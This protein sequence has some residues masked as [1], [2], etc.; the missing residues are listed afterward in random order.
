[1]KKNGYIVKL[2][3]FLIPIFLFSCGNS[4]NNNNSGNNER[5]VNTV[6]RSLMISGNFNNSYMLTAFSL[7]D[8]K[9]T[10]D[11]P[12]DQINETIQGECGGELSLVSTGQDVLTGEGDIS[13]TFSEFDDCESIIS[14]ELIFSGKVDPQTNIPLNSSIV[15]YSFYVTTNE[16]EYTVD[17]TMSYDYTGDEESTTLDLQLENS[18]G[19]VSDIIKFACG[20]SSI[21]GMNFLFGL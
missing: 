3:F 11:I 13:F 8:E 17:G 4:D 15:F 9:T 20:Y 21:E 12:L 14:G 6:D 19:D 18:Q 2:I 5:S 10:D 16:E 1:M 7:L